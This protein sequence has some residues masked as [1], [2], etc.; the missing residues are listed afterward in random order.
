M[1]RILIIDDEPNAR[2]NFRLA[3]EVEGYQVTEAPSG[4]AAMEKLSAE[5]FDLTLLDLRMPGVGGL[6]LLE[7]MRAGGISTPVIIITAFGSVPDAVQAMKLG[8]IDFLEKPLR[9]VDLRRLVAEVVGR[10]QVE[11]RERPEQDDYETHLQAAKRHINLRHFAL[12]EKHLQRALEFK[13]HSPDALNLLGVLAELRGDY[14][15]ARKYYGQAIRAQ[16]DH[17]AAQQNMRRLFELDHFGVTD[18]PLNLGD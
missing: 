14:R 6:E 12:A 4:A 17:E 2:L 9:P 5:Q 13:T 1:K 18:E 7:Q 10:H 15:N 8:A 3:L 16:H 11:P